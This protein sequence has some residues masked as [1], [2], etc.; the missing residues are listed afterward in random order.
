MEGALAE[1][2]DSVTGVKPFISRCS[3]DAK[4]GGATNRRFSAFAE[5]A[6]FSEIP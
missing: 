3:S 4:D 6:Y 1:A 2:A 5:M